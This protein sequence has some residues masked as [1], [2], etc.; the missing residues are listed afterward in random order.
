MSGYPDYMRSP[1]P[2]S[3]PA[4]P[5]DWSPKRTEIGSDGGS[6]RANSSGRGQTRSAY[7]LQ[8]RQH[9]EAESSTLPAFMRAPSPSSFPTPSF[10]WPR[11]HNITI[12]SQYGSPAS[13]MES[14]S[15]ETMLVTSAFG[16]NRVV[17]PRPS[18]PIQLRAADVE[19][20]S[21]HVA[22]TGVC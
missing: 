1:S 6:E 14:D 21:A 12:T 16:G 13:D 2:S 4:P 15:S 18:R 19:D 10:D 8:D 11:Q 22:A 7:R 17:C 3:F 5:L 9:K 20:M